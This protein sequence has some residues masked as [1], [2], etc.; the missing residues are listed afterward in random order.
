MLTQPV[1]WLQVRY[2]KA[3]EAYNSKKKDEEEEKD[4][5]DEEEADEDEDE[6]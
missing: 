4:D 5:E 2:A 3:I 1:L 6:D